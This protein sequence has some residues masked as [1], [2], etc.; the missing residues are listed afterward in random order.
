M[1]ERQHP[2][3]G[4]NVFEDVCTGQVYYSACFLPVPFYLEDFCHGRK[5]VV[6]LQTWTM[7]MDKRVMH[8][9]R[10]GCVQ[11]IKFIEVGCACVWP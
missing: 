2:E 10:A 11:L 8:S 1:R 6:V 4:F 9:I 7:A 3:V 5:S